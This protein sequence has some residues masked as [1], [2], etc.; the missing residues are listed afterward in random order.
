M[1]YKEHIEKHAE[2]RVRSGVKKG[3]KF[4]FIVLFAAGVFLLAVYALQ[5]LW[6]WLMPELF[7]LTAIT[8]GQA[9]GIMVLAKLLFGMGGGCNR[10]GGRFRKS[11]RQSCRP[12]GKA[13]DKW[14]YYDRFWKE[15]GAAAYEQFVARIERGKEGA[16]PVENQPD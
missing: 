5:L 10:R 13:S 11:N 8:Y 14:W 6:N 1:D 15:E 4:F 7:G 12:N 9:L 16:A 3:V 2:A